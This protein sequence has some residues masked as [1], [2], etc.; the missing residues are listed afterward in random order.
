MSGQ[1]RGLCAPK[2]ANKGPAW[3]Q[4]NIAEL[5]DLLKADV[6]MGAPTLGLRLNGRS[7]VCEFLGSVPA[8]DQRTKFRFIVTRAKS[9]A[10]TGGLPP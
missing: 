1:R 7:T 5:S 8:A 3:Q 6:V 4:A 2:I 9:S 10:T